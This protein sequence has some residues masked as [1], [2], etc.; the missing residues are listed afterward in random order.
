MFLLSIDT[1][2]IASSVSCG[3]HIA[4]SCKDCSHDNGTNWCDGDCMLLNE[5]CI[6]KPNNAYVGN[7]YCNDQANNTE[8]N[9][10]GGDCFGCVG[11]CCSCE[12]ITL[13]LK[14]N[15]YEAQGLCDDS[16]GVS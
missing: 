6:D 10:D 15:A 9:Y 3:S 1:V 5:Q 4:D 14:N 7:G 16:C 8:C 13:T 12:M 2:T 11:D